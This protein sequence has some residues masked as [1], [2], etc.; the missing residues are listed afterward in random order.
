MLKRASLQSWALP[1]R[2]RRERAESIRFYLSFS[3]CLSPLALIEARMGNKEPSRVG[4]M[5]TA[6]GKTSVVQ[7]LLP[8]V[9]PRST[10][11][12]YVYIKIRGSAAAVAA[13][14]SIYIY[15][16]IYIQPLQYICMSNQSREQRIYKILAVVQHFCPN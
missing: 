5:K 12:I 3:E 7:S 2:G 16:Y 1:T 14:G 8:H 15:I 4:G 9:Q 13:S 10:R 6:L 11:S